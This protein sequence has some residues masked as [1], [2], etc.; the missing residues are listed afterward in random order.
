ME[1]SQFNSLHNSRG[2]HLRLMHQSVQSKS[3]VISRNFILGFL[4]PLTC[5]SIQSIRRIPILSLL[6]LLLK[7]LQFCFIAPTPQHQLLI[8]HY[9]G[10][11]YR[12]VRKLHPIF[13]L[14]TKSR[15]L[16]PFV[17]NVTFRIIFSVYSAYF[18]VLENQLPTRANGFCYVDL[19]GKIV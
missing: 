10:G 5:S 7:Y 13:L 17:E 8:T 9:H 4:S 3:I 11:L 12:N 18:F 6:L 1:N 19:L 14:E 2:N 16:M 15:L